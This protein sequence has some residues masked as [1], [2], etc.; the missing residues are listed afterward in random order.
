MRA[1]SLPV[2]LAVPA[3]AGESESQGH[4]SGQIR[5]LKGTKEQ[6]TPVGEQSVRV[7]K[8]KRRRF[9]VDLHFTVTVYT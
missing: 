2:L 1:S 5:S 8:L 4:G 7:V 9:I 6:L 3:L